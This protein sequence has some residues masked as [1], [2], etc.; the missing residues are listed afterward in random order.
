[1]IWIKLLRMSALGHKQTLQCKT[2]C[3]LYPNSG[4]VQ[5]NSEC[6]LSA[7]GGHAL[8]SRL[9]K[10]AAN[11]GGLLTFSLF[12]SFL[13]G[14]NTG[15]NLPPVVTVFEMVGAC[16]RLARSDRLTITLISPVVIPT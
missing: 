8:A 12:Y 15:G 13:C 6:P 4:Q 11:W 9:N 14:I 16:S 10:E 2:A 3:P 5:C 1:M 7:N